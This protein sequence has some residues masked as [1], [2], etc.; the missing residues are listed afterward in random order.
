MTSKEDYLQLRM[1]KSQKEEIKRQAKNK[2]MS[3]TGYIWYLVLEKLKEEKN[4]I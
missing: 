3:M 2:C 1:F 4:G